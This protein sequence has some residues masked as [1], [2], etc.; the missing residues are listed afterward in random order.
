MTTVPRDVVA[1]LIRQNFF[2]LLFRTRA[3]PLFVWSL[4]AVRLPV[5]QN[6]RKYWLKNR[7]Q[8]SSSEG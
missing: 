6:F 4:C 1:K 2:Y 5:Q 7:V 8:P 3:F